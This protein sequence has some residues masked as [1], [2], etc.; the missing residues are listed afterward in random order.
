[1]DRISKLNTL[2][3]KYRLKQ[4][5]YDGSSTYS[6]IVEIKTSPLSFSLFQNYPNP[7]N[8]T[9]KIQYWLPERSR[10]RLT[11]YDVLGRE[12]KTLV[13]EEKPAGFY[14]AK[15]D[16]TGVPSG[17]YFYRIE[18]GTFSDTKKFVLLK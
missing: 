14:E 8:P 12:I 4:I 15:F 3:L 18:A 9:T 1:M 7:F 11:I 17:V 13:N 2:A 5:D 10:V 6:Q 16:G